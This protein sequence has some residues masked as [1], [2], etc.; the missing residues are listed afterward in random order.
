MVCVYWSPSCSGSGVWPVKHFVDWFLGVTLSM[1]GAVVA[2][3]TH[4]GRSEGGAEMWA[5]V[6]L[7]SPLACC[8]LSTRRLV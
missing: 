2:A 1:F 3:V 5:R 8:W 7:L 4:W 6:S